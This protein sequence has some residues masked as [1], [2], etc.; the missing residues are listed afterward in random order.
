MLPT[1]QGARTGPQAWEGAVFL[2]LP[3]GLP[4]FSSW[5]KAGRTLCCS[6]LDLPLLKPT[7]QKEPLLLQQLLPEETLWSP[8]LPKVKIFNHSVTTM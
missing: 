6:R 2:P 4:G 1:A 3:L 7:W 5:R 8:I